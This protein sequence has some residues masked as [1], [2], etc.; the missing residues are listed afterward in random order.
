MSDLQ[1]IGPRHST[2]VENIWKKKRER[3]QAFTDQINYGLFVR[4][5]MAG[6][7]DCYY[8]GHAPR[9]LVMRFPLSNAEFNSMRYYVA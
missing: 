9:P 2:I 7:C 6:F 3:L 4:F 5:H 1:S 8:L